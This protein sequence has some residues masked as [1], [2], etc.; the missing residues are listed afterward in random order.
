MARQSSSGTSF[1]TFALLFLVALPAAAADSV[2]RNGI[3]PWITGDEGRTFF[4]FSTDP[5]PSGFFCGGSPAFTGRVTFKGEP[6][7]TSPPD[8]LGGADT[9]VQRLD[10]ARFDERGVAYT[11]VQVRALSFSSIEPVKTACGPFQVSVSLDGPQQPV[12]RMKIVRDHD[13]G[14]RYLAA[15]SLGVRIAFTPLA[16]KSSERLELT[17][18]ATFPVLSGAF[19]STRPGNPGLTREGFFLADTDG[20]GKPDTF[21]PGTS[22]FAPGWRSGGDSAVEPD[23]SPTQHCID[24][25]EGC[26]CMN[27]AY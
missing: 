13:Q 9:I 17:R 18:S 22:N 1:I 2:I 21:L 5:I 3:D 19:W 4:D 8:A 25:G 15:I 7:A 27:C 14:G 20:D 26:H 12:T 10:D 6:I 16:G 23:A 11:R 24:A